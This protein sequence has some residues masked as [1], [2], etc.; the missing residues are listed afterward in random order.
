M[1]VCPCAS[2]RYDKLLQSMAGGEPVPAVGFGFGDAV[3]VELLKVGP[4]RP[5]PC[6]CA[7]LTVMSRCGGWDEIQEKNL[8]PQLPRD[9]VQVRTRTST[10]TYVH[11]KPNLCTHGTVTGGGLR[12]GVRVTP[13]GR[14]DRFPTTA[15]AG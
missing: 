9:D 10:S 3:I 4:P 14:S 11:V 8:L 6:L 5:C 12:D 7:C 2:G 15:R 1:F 13:P